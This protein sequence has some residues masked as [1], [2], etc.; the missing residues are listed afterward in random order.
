MGK[1]K[2]R[3]E[4]LLEDLNASTGA[5]EP[6]GVSAA[7]E[8]IGDDENDY[9]Y[10]EFSSIS[11]VTG[12]ASDGEG[13]VVVGGGGGDR[14][15]GTGREKA[16]DRRVA[17]AI[18]GA[19]TV[20]TGR[21]EQKVQQRTA[22]LE[23]RLAILVEENRKKDVKHLEAMHAREREFGKERESM[24]AALSD[25]KK[26]QADLERLAPPL[27]DAIA[28]A[29]SQLQRLVCSPERMRDLETMPAT[30]LSLPEFCILRVH[31]ETATLR[32]E[33]G[34]ARVER[35]AARDAAARAELGNEQLKREA[36]RASASIGAAEQESAAERQ[37]WPSPQFEKTSQRLDTVVRA[38]TLFRAASSGVTLVLLVAGMHAPPVYT[39][40]HTA[41]VPSSRCIARCFSLWET[42]TF[43]SSEGQSEKPHPTE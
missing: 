3:L 10:S 24:L 27:K 17:D 37:G 31:Q 29:K 42:K 13:V 36:K 21:L 34:V 4:R 25:L 22:K 39:R 12:E 14:G 15:G 16:R 23:E 5:I 33:L 19:G 9:P 41:D 32:D 40:T 6:D 28:D 7:V 26:K 2:E 1:A 38:M 8:A 18:V 43:W 30:Q 11:D 20:Y 35:D